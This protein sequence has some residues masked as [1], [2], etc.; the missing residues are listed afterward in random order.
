[1]PKTDI[2]N[3]LGGVATPGQ[4]QRERRRQLGVDEKAHGGS[5]SEEHRVVRLGGGV[6]EAGLDISGL[7]IG[8]VFED[9]GLRDAS[10]EEIEHVL[11]ANAHAADAGTAATLMGTEGDTVDH[12]YW[13]RGDS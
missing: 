13:C 6:V 4:K 7:Q 9:F 5:A 10:G 11:D 3:V 8:E 2:G 12:G 1:M